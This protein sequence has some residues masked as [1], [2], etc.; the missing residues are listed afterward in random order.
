MIVPEME[1][2]VVAS[3]SYRDEAGR[4][5]I[6][7][8]DGVELEAV[9]APPPNDARDLLVIS[10]HGSGQSPGEEPMRTLVDELPG[11]GYGALGL[12]TRQHGDGVNTD[13]LFATLRDVDAAVWVGRRL[14]Y[15]R[16]VLH[17]HSLGSL[18]SLAY[19]AMNWSRDLVGLVLTGMFANLPWKSRHLLIQEAELYERLRREAFELAAAGR[20]GEVLSTR[21]PWLEGETPVTAEHFLTYRCTELD[22]ASSAHWIR[23]VPVPILLVRDDADSVIRDFEPG[24]LETA[25]RQGLSPSIVGLTLRSERPS[26]GH[27][28]ETTRGQLVEQVVAWLDARRHDEAGA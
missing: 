11:R 25:G 6:V 26:D 20:F 1:R 16:L 19:C 10:V 21:M 7:T 8:I 28:F 17:G 14:G 15:A 12:R 27:C 5:V 23:A 9:H 22:L 24:W 13:N 18:Q 3:I 2:E 4:M